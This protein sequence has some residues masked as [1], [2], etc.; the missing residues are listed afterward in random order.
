MKTINLG[1]YRSRS[2][3]TVSR[4]FTGRERG[5]QVRELSKIDTLF[6]GGDRVTIIVPNDIFS[7][8]P[9]FLE[10]LFKNVVANNSKKEI[11]DRLTVEGRYDLL[12]PLMEAIDRIEQSKTAL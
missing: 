10:E 1:D 4:V 8:T 5:K 9:S 3:N 6:N 2:G 12:S 11:L 7:I